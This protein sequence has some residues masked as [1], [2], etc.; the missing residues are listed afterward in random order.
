MLPE[1]SRREWEEIA[2][3]QNRTLIELLLDPFFYY[4]LKNKNFNSLEE[5]PC[6]KFSGML[7]ENKNQ[8]EFWFK[9]K[10]I[11]KSNTAE[12]VNEMFLFPMFNLQQ[13]QDSFTSQK[14][15]YLVNKEIGNLG[16]YELKV[17][18]E[19]LLL[20]NFIVETELFQR[21]KIISSIS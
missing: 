4:K 1:K 18:E 7:T 9:N 3:K 13:A 8:V 10:K 15:I 6:D 11:F 17:Q 12:I 21:S 19:K 20:D 16:V 5:F 2:I 14:G